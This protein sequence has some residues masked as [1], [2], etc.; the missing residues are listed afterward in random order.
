VK[1]DVIGKGAFGSVR[2]V[3]DIHDGEIY[4]MKTVGI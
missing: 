4:A 3:K 2:M 1:K